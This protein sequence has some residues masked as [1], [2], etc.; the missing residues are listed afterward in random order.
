MR[1]SSKHVFE[2]LNKSARWAFFFSIFSN[3]LMLSVPLYTIMIYDRVLVSNSMDTLLWLTILAVCALLVYGILDAIKTNILSKGS[4]RFERELMEVVVKSATKAAREGAATGQKPISDV[5]EV[6]NM[7]TQGLPVLMDLPWSFIFLIVVSFLHPYLGIAGLFAVM[8]LFIM[9][10]FLSKPKPDNGISNNRILQ[11][12]LSGNVGLLNAA[13]D[14]TIVEMWKKGYLSSASEKMKETLVTGYVGAA[15][16]AIRIAMPTVI[17]A[18]GAYLVLQHQLTPGGMIAASMLSGRILGPFDRLIP[19]WR[20]Y[21]DGNKSLVSLENLVNATNGVG[22]DGSHGFPQSSEISFI[23][24]FFRGK[25][26]RVLLQPSSFTIKNNALVAVVGLSGSGKTILLNL[27]SGM[28]KPSAGSVRIGGIETSK[29]PFGYV[30]QVDEQA[31]FL[32]GTIGENIVGY[33]EDMDQSDRDEIV[34]ILGL[35]DFISKLPK[36]FDTNVE[37]IQGYLFTSGIRR[38]FV[39]GRSFAGNKNIRIIENVEFGLDAKLEK[40]FFQLLQR[41][42]RKGETVFYSCHRKSLVQA[43]DLFIAMNNGKIETMQSVQQQPN[44]PQVAISDKQENV[45]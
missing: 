3:A 16:R 41:A 30:H 32:P 45:K 22:E 26:G 10:G 38:S 14:K 39:L 1:K 44:A 28:L 25:D 34:S 40:A 36:G 29:I 23:D 37:E 17:L 31:G 43:A 35:N 33:Q 19:V 11:S 5:F 12:V 27:I 4:L 42:K 9:S 21:K 2:N 24:V 18:T 6:K 13:D 15:G 7:T 8:A 20:Q